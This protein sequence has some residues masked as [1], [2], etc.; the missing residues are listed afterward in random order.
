MEVVVTGP[1]SFLPLLLFLPVFTVA[2]CDI[3][4]FLFELISVN[5]GLLRLLLFIYVILGGL[6]HI[7]QLLSFLL[8]LDG[9]NLPEKTLF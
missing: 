5:D 1:L 7:D 2:S 9:L 6:L 4:E 8:L 3:V